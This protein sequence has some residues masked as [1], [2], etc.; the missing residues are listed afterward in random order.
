MKAARSGTRLARLPGVLYLRN[1]LSHHHPDA[2][3]RRFREQLGRDVAAAIGRWPALTERQATVVV[4]RE[5]RHWS[6]GEIAIHLGG[7]SQ[8]A[9]HNHYDRAIDKMDL[10]TAEAVN[11]PRE[12]FLPQEAV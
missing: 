9:C 12:N 1:R 5:V 6:W 10:A 8:T 7:I 2:L 11:V 4:L 3:H